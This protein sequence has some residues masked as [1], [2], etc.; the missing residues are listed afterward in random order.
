MSET[1]EPFLT[2]IP[3]RLDRLPWSRFHWL[4]LFA[5]GITWILDGLEVTLK[6]A[7]SGVLQMPQV[8][9][10]TPE[11]I[12]SIA[13]FYLTGVVLGRYFDTVGRR[14][15]ISATYTVSALLLAATGWLF[16]KGAL[17]AASQTALWSVIFFFAS[18][19]ASAL[20][21]ALG[22]AVGG[23]VAPWLFGAL[24]GSGSRGEVFSGY[25][26]AAA[27][28]LAAAVVELLFGVKAEQ[29]SLESIAEPLSAG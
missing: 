26:A 27:L 6:G 20:F 1:S 9:N 22:T 5:L 8:M 13:S 4:I 21:V 23:V 12:G 29:A 19:A 18:A 25:V 24:V 14:P 17:S 16:T 2:H 7:I 10:L 3:A 28:M 11:Q 15:M